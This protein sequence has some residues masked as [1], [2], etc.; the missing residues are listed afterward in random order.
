MKKT[1]C[2]II[3]GILIL[4][5]VFNKTELFANTSIKLV[6]L[7]MYLIKNAID[8]VS[9]QEY[10]DSA[11]RIGKN[12][13][14]I[15]IEAFN[16]SQ[17]SKTIEEQRKAFESNSFIIAIFSDK[18]LNLTDSFKQDLFTEL[19]EAHLF[20]RNLQMVPLRLKASDSIASDENMNKIK[21]KLQNP[22]LKTITKFFIKYMLKFYDNSQP[23]HESGEPIKR[24]E[25]NTPTFEDIN[26][27]LTENSKLFFD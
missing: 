15:I 24:F 5:I 22:Q 17:E 10:L 21:E 4:L 26:K 23:S 14:K 12:Y 27:R 11:E 3:L 25:K 19:A 6:E 13:L 16:K 18:N 1:I 20:E 7:D 9:N 2:F 8:H